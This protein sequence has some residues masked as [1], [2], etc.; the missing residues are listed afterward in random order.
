MISPA[1]TANRCKYMI[2]L[3]SQIKESCPRA[4]R[5]QDAE[6]LY[7]NSRGEVKENFSAPGR[8]TTF[9]GPD[10]RQACPAP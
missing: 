6:A 9:S 1:I 2:F 5:L 10:A 3:L 7:P 8:K 4:L